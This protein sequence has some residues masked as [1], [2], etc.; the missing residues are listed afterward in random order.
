MHGV[1]NAVASTP[2]KKAPM[3]PS[4]LDSSLALV[5]ASPPKVTSNTPNKFNA[6]STTTSNSTRLKYGFCICIPHD[7]ICVVF[8]AEIN[9]PA[10][11]RND[12]HTPSA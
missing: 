10:N 12:A 1:A 3:N 6:T 9:T 7:A 8:L 4:R 5:I 2:L 11:A